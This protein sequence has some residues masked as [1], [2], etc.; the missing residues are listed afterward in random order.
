MIIIELSVCYCFFS[1]WFAYSFNYFVWRLFAGLC[2][3]IMC[4]QRQ[5]KPEESIRSARSGVTDSC[6]LLCGLL[7]S[8]PL[9]STAE[10]CLWP[11]LKIFV[12]Q[13]VSLHS[14]RKQV[15]VDCLQMIQALLKTTGTL[16][17]T[18]SHANRSVC[19][20]TP[21]HKHPGTQPCT[22]IQKCMGARLC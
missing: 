20:H 1:R 18:H 5:Q 17:H 19:M 3:C 4:M 6:A 10:P 9:F 7:K 21:T 22:W 16:M 14:L 11:Q 8:H 12:L 13:I 15:K 2:L